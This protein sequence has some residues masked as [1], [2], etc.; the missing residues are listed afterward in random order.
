MWPGQNNLVWFTSLGLGR[1]G[2]VNASIPVNLNVTT[3][4]N[5]VLQR[6]ASTSITTRIMTGRY[7][8][9]TD[10]FSIGLRPIT[11]DNPGNEFPNQLSNYTSTLQLVPSQ[12][13]QTVNLPISS[14]WN[15][16]IGPRNV[17]ITISNGDVNVNNFV[18]VNI[19][20]PVAPYL[21]SG[22][23]IAIL[24][25][26]IILVLKRPKRLRVVKTVTMSKKTVQQP[27]RK[28]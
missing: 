21:V 24:L 10:S 4:S 25:G 6:G 5:I 11:P 13:S 20:D 15:S 8:S 27:R 12:T 3:P 17:A 28:K 7:Y 14:A 26:A 23:A 22:I 19:V 18:Q 16:T 9:G 2:Y 1:I